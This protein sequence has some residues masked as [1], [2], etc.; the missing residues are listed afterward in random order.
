MH[1]VLLIALAILTRAALQPASPITRL[2]TTTGTLIMARTNIDL[3]RRAVSNDARTNANANSRNSTPDPRT[4]DDDRKLYT[5]LPTFCKYHHSHAG[6]PPP[7]RRNETYKRLLQEG[8]KRMPAAMWVKG[9]LEE[10][11]PRW[12]DEYCAGE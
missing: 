1:T 8:V 7:L 9:E 12:F 3:L 5:L 2:L 11:Y 6:C 10:V 4:T